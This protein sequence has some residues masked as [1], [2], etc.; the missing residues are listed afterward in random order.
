MAAL[1]SYTTA[2]RYLG[3]EGT[4]QDAVI[5]DLVDQIST[6]VEMRCGRPFTRQTYTERY[7]RAKACSTLVL[8]HHPV[9]AIT[10]I[11]DNATGEAVDLAGVT[12]DA[13]G[14]V[15]LG[16]PLS[17]VSV[18]YDAGYDVTPADVQGAVLA[19]LAAVWQDRTRS[20]FQMGI[21]DYRA[22]IDLA[23]PQVAGILDR[24]PRDVAF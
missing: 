11:T 22:A 13:A 15:D 23:L 14:I 6:E 5:T 16:S 1:V 12:Y 21:G 24:Y 4:D 9:L 10:S 2:K 18:T 8:T 3:I 19:I 20:S 17:D 7:A